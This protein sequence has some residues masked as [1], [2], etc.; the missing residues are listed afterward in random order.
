M[1]KDNHNPLQKKN[2]GFISF[3]FFA[4]VSEATKK[5]DFRQLFDPKIQHFTL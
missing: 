5:G 3:S 4:R 1:E 2:R